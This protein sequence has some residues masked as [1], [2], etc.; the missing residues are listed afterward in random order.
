M[1]KRTVNSELIHAFIRQHYPDGIKRLSDITRIPT[2]TIAKIRAGHVPVSAL[3]R[4]SLA[5]GLGV[6]E[7]ALF[8]LESE[9]S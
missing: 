9:A 7:D 2:T 5:E 6:K 1:P 3:Q 4:W 8:P